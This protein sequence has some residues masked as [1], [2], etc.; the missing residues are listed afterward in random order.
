MTRYALGYCP[1][2]IKL[3]TASAA[4]CGARRKRRTPFAACFAIFF[5]SFLFPFALYFHF[6]KSKHIVNF[7]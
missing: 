6:F 7:V 2:L 3:H 5:F 1:A 4:Y